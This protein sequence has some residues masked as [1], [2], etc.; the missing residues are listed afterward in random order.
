MLTPRQAYDLA[1]SWGSFVRAGDP[2]AVFYSFRP[3]DARPN[4]EGHRR[5]CLI[6]VGDLIR[7]GVS[8]AAARELR[9]LRAFFKHTGLRA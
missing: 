8:D 6:Y 7:Q 3:G 1:S 5:Q 9:A 2:G 4:D